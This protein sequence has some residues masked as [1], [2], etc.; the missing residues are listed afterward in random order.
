MKAIKK[1]MLEI[2][3]C[4]VYYCVL[5]IKIILKIKHRQ[6]S[7]GGAVVR[8]KELLESHLFSGKKIIWICRR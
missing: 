8:S 3:N 7:G 6:Q 5:F 2:L 1:K 4:Q